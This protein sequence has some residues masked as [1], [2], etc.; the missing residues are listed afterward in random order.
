MIL[1]VIDT[2]T[3]FA[4]V[5]I[6][7]D[8][9]RRAT[10][11]WRSNQNHGRELMPALVESL[12]ELSLAPTDITHVAVALG[13]GG[14]SA[15]RVGIS[16]TLGLA[17]AKHLPVLGVP[18]HDIEI[19]PFGQLVTTGIP[20]YSLIPAGRQEISWTRH[21]EN[22]GTVSLD[23]RTGIAS[24][25]AML[26]LIEPDALLCG[27]AC[28]LMIG[29]IG[30]SRFAR[31]AESGSTEPDALKQVPEA[32]RDPNSLLDIAIAKFEAGISTPFEE[33][34]PIYARPPS[35]SRPKSAK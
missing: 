23:V 27:E 16:A 29:L 4:G 20:V 31:F 15:V 8:S 2:S 34:R 21:S 14:F 30:E 9:G 11:A 12:S 33:L 10:R 25:Q 3:R 26:N 7:D 35:I 17:I 32:T 1:A 6:I 22:S 18:T 13:P 19:A 28:D 5:G 24:P